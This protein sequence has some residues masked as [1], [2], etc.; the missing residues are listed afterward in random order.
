M[1]DKQI[2]LLAP[3]GDVEAI[4]AAIVA[5]ANAVYCGLDTFN[6]RNRAVNLSIEQLHG[7]LRL[8]HKYHCKVFLTLN[9]IVLE[10]ELKALFNLL[11]HLV[12]TSIDGI[13]VQDLGLFTII[14]RYFPSLD[15]H[16]STQLTTHN[17]GQIHFLH[18]L[19]A[20]RV[21]L[22]RE[23]SILEISPLNKVIHQCDMLSEVFVHGSLCVA[24]SGQCYTTSVTEGNSGNRGRCSQACRDQYLTHS[25]NPYPLNLK[26]NSAFH[27]LAELLAAGADSLKIEGRIKGAHY[28]YTVVDTWRKQLDYNLGLHK[29]VVDDSHLHKVFNRDFTDGFLTGKLS[30][31]MFI[32]NPTDS[33]LNKAI[34]FANADSE[35]E[36]NTVKNQLKAEKDALGKQLRHKILPLSIEK[37]AITLDFSGKQNEPLTICVNA[38]QFKY[39]VSS[40]CSL[41]LAKD[42]ELTP[43]LL[44]KRFKSCDNFDYQVDQF[45]FNNLDKKLTLPYQ[46]LTQLKNELM[47]YL[48]HGV[49][50]KPAVEYTNVKKIENNQ[51]DIKSTSLESNKSTLGIVISSEDEIVNFNDFPVKIYFKTPEIYKKNDNTYIELFNKYDHII[52]WFP[53]I[54]IGEDYTQA[55]K[56]LDKCQPNIIVTNNTGIAYEAYK[57]N[58]SWIAG[59]QLNI[60]NSFALK[61]LQHEF[62]A[63][64]GFIS[65]E[66][67]RM[68]I[69]NIAKPNNLSL[70]YSIYHPSLLMVSRQCLLQQSIHCKKKNVTTSC[71]H[72][73]EKFTEITN[74]KNEKFILDKKRSYY[75]ASYLSKHYLNIDVIKDLPNY[76]DEYLMDFTQVANQKLSLEEKYRF[77]K[78]VH[79]YINGDYS[80][81]TEILQLIPNT[82]N[83]Q[84]INGL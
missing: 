14:K 42:K 37:I 11:N 33:S 34:K 2:E 36:I 56:L 24:F 58:I 29:Q 4:K 61:T 43:E 25:N 27:Q 75:S 83:K 23:L 66:I 63:T 26:D 3:G 45:V 81:G 65:N 51:Q 71:L 18:Q 64:G 60:T 5:G 46:A 55:V 82:Q 53:A 79:G 74:L 22:C 54:L 41:Q 48:N 6:A 17:E 69:K 67:N 76:F 31:S 57:R 50:I 52:P 68:Q 28:V 21:N 39:K 13:I 19:G 8:A 80:L 44:Q 32:D 10:R 77:I 62:S 84:Y 35:Q 20:S 12:N 40:K 15:I 73:C 7:I 70:F 16:G 9:I 72:R 30:Q 1:Q 78:L 47:T 38:L 49:K 59:P